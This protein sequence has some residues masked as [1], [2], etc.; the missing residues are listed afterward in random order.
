MSELV[1]E[2]GG[3]GDAADKNEDQAEERQ[4]IMELLLTDFD[5]NAR[6]TATGSLPTS[7]DEGEED[8]EGENEEIDLNELLSRN[9][10]DYDFYTKMDS[11]EIKVDDFYKSPGLATDPNEIPDWIRYPHGSEGSTKDIGED[12]ILIDPNQKRASA[13]AARYTD[14]MTEKQFLRAMEKQA[15]AEE[16]A[17]KARKAEWK[18]KREL[19]ISAAVDV[20][21]AVKRGSTALSNQVVDRLISMCKSVIALRDPKTKRRLSDMFREKPSRD[22]YPQYYQII[23]NPIGINDIMRKCRAFEYT[24]VREFHS[25][26]SLLFNNALKFNGEGSWI[27]ED[28]KV[29]E[30]ELNRLIT[31]HKMFEQESPPKKLQKPRIKLSLKNLVSKRKKDESSD[32]CENGSPR[33]KK[34]K[35]S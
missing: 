14:G 19:K 10:E 29:L 26:W 22:E 8:A 5:S 12:G 6:G 33:K 16:D 4:K 18:E 7:E 1:V 20:D 32:G 23:E 11:G 17:I 34:S 24:S 28:S 27:V 2:A 25:D 31:K 30:N 9:D 3:F 13:Q 35:M 15:Q 21:T